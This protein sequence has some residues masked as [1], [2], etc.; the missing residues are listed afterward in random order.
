MEIFSI[1]GLWCMLKSEAESPQKRYL[2][3]FAATFRFCLIMHKLQANQEASL[4]KLDLARNFR[5]VKRLHGGRM[6][7]FFMAGWAFQRGDTGT[8]W[9]SKALTLSQIELT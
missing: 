7:S 8:K 5:N 9:G 2:S 1:F 3:S 4:Q 6:H